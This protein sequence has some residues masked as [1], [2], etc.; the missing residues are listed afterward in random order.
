MARICDRLGN[1]FKFDDGSPSRF[2]KRPIIIS[3]IKV[4][5]TWFIDT[6]EGTMTASPGIILS[7]E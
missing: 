3:A 6:L 5:R 7:G 4:D 1:E 2:R